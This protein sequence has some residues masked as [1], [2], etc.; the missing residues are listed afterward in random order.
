MINQNTPLQIQRSFNAFL[1][2]KSYLFYQFFQ[3][4]IGVKLVMHNNVLHFQIKEG[5]ALELGKIDKGSIRWV[6]FQPID[7]KSQ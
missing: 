5:R 7:P 3:V 2:V 1:S 6:P 4:V